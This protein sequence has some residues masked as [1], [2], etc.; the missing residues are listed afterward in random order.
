M[1]TLEFLHQGSAEHIK[2]LYFIAVGYPSDSGFR[3]C[4]FFFFL[5]AR[6]LLYNI[7]LVSAIH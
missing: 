4:L 5:I 7:V 3:A 6:Y 1:G 2:M